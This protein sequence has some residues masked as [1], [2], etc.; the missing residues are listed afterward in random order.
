MNQKLHFFIGKGGV[1][2]STSSAIS[3][4]YLSNNKIKT[5]LVSIDPAH[6]QRDLFNKDFSE[7]K[8]KIND[9]LSVIEVDESF[10]IKKYLA[11]VKKEV[12][13]TY[14]Y[15]TA[16]NL[17]KYFKILKYSPGIE[18]YALLLAIE[19]VLK[20]N[21]DVEYIIFD[22]PPTALTL[23]IFSLP[24]TTSV[25]LEELLKLRLEI[26]KKKEIISKIKLGKIEIE[27]DK[28]K[29]SLDRMI[30]HYSIL[31]ELFLSDKVLINIVKNPDILSLSESIRL[32]S[33]I[34]DLEMHINSIIINKYDPKISHSKHESYKNE[35]VVYIKNSEKRLNGF[36]ALSNFADTY[37]DVFKGLFSIES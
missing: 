2:K 30:I 33:K 20:K 5:L 37:K 14:T 16:F 25:W 32:I 27:T 13:E 1:G 3:A 24:L 35:K 6:N 7:K 34:R 4:I 17:D 22:M 9:Y 12:N 29:N 19:N 23:K 11:Q 15:Q 10:W 18:E 31:R 26:Y 8:M 28:V 21:L 36:D